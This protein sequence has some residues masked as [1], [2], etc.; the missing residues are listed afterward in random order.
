MSQLLKQILMGGDIAA[1][2]FLQTVNQLFHDNQFPSGNSI[3]QSA[4][5]NLEM[6]GVGRLRRA[7]PI[8][9]S[10]NNPIHSSCD[11][12]NLPTF[13]CRLK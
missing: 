3:V 5:L 11:R 4:L 1:P 10:I 7:I 6:M 12:S 9:P 13:Y 8:I 2:K